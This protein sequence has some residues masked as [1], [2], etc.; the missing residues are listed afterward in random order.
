MSSVLCLQIAHV[1]LC[2]KMCVLLVDIFERF[3]VQTPLKLFHWEDKRS[4]ILLSL[5]KT[6]AR[7]LGVSWEERVIG[8]LIVSPSLSRRPSVTFLSVPS[9]IYFGG[10]NP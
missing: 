9:L 10:H 6:V 1:A 5:Y 2:T 3:T 4:F 8:F 7:I